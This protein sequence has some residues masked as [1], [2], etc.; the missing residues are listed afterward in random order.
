MAKL[1]TDPLF[2]QQWYLYNT[3]QGGRTPGIDLNVVDVWE[4]YTGKGVTIG[5]LDDGVDDEHED[6]ADNYNSQPTGLTPD[7]NPAEGKPQEP[8]LEGDNH[9]TAVA[10]IIAGVANN[11]TGI[12]GVAYNAQITGFRYAD[13][14]DTDV[15][16]IA[17]Q[18]AFDISNNSWG[19]VNPF[20][21]NFNLPTDRIAQQALESAITNGRNGLGTIFVWAAGNERK[22]GVNANYRNY[23]NSRYA[24]AVAAINGNGIYAPYSVPGANLLVSAF[25]DEDPNTGSGTILT[26]DRMGNA[27]YNAPGVEGEVDNFNYTG[28][29]N[30]TSSA[31]PM[32]SGVVALILEANPNLGYRDVQEILAYSAR[33][34]DRTEADWSFNGAR[35]WNGGG[36]HINHNYGFGLVDTHA[37]VR[38]A[39]SWMLESTKANER[40]VSG[41]S[42]IP[43]QIVDQGEITDTITLSSD[44]T[45]DYAEID[46]D[47]SHTAIEDL[48]ITLTSPD[49]T[50]SLLFDGIQLQETGQI[51]VGS[52]D[53]GDKKYESFSSFRQ[54]PRGF[55]DDEDLIA[56]GESYQQGIKF[57]FSSTFNWGEIGTGDWK[58]TVKDTQEEDIG[59]LNSWNL[60]LFGDE[61]TTDNFYIYTN[62]FGQ[63]NDVSR[64]TLT[65]SEGIDTINAAAIRSD[66]VLDLTQ[67]SASTLASKPLTIAENT[68]IENAIAGDGND[69]ITGNDADNQLMGGRGNDTLVGGAGNDSLVG[70]LGN[71]SLVGG[72]G[73]DTLVGGPG[74]NILQGDAGN[75]VYVI[76]VETAAGNQIEDSDGEDTF[77]TVIPLS[78][79]TLTTGTL[80]FGRE[81][82]T[83]VL[84][85][86]QDGIVNLDDDLAILNFFADEIGNAPGTGLIENWPD[87]SGDDILTLFAPPP[88]ANPVVVSEDPIL[89]QS[90]PDSS[91]DSSSGSPDTSS[92]D[93]LNIPPIILGEP[94][95]NT[96][97]TTLTGS[98][99]DDVIFGT[100]AAEAIASFG[101]NDFLYGR[102]GDDN[103][104]GGE[105]NDLLHGN[106]GNDFLD[107]GAGD[108]WIH[109]GQGNDAILGNEG[110]DVLFGDLGN[111]LIFGGNDNDFLNGNQGDDSLDAGAGTDTLHGGQGN[112]ILIGGSGNDFLYG[113]KGD[114]TLV[115]VDTRSATPGQ[116]EIDFL[117]GGEGSD[118]FVLGD[119]TR[120]YYDGDS[121]GGYAIL[122]DFNAVQD[123]IQ[124]KGS[125]ANYLLFSYVD[126]GSNLPRTDIYLDKPGT[127]TD[128]LIA[129]IQGVSDLSL[130]GNYFN[131]V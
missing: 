22:E 106:Q 43:V 82:T 78:L 23:E 128:D 110:N 56:L 52:D 85:L 18:A 79:T 60:R 100:D 36:L 118:L 3:G 72:A 77:S 125:A 131:F 2:S 113:D 101:G 76:A 114:D 14:T 47:I 59:T 12:A 13:I 65:D 115:G 42:S 29:F 107:G 4:E 93:R 53:E 126:E 51:L 25:G 44:L 124:L 81:G 74:A 87:F 90:L 102:E 120:V 24:I 34:N 37:A 80:G 32:V 119:S 86:N 7:Y 10:G 19:G 108:D 30:G 17:R 67:G 6:L 33:Q 16:P 21:T 49:G 20:E 38:L 62:E 92:G 70:D 68:V 103:L 39:E 109:G 15:S 98:N 66:L 48:S 99:E 41:S 95:P 55:T 121:N 58:L 122:T 26:T 31:T 94:T 61:M 96:V 71:D 46:L 116:G 123:R 130:Q 83:L 35:N 8:G 5:V 63:L 89:P 54:N 9:G 84:D 88:P 27:G 73:D 97:T 1:P 57:T 111:D 28:T 75:D 11:G 40:Q 117:T 50:E 91:S 127:E 112:D 64:Q 69:N 105:G 45:I 129:V 104:Y